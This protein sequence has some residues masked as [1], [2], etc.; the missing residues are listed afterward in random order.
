MISFCKGSKDEP[1]VSPLSLDIPITLP[2]K[3]I[4]KSFSQSG[5][6]SLI[7]KI[8]SIILGKVIGMPKLKGDTA[9]PSFDPLQNEQI[10]PDAPSSKPVLPKNETPNRFWAFVEPYCAPIAQDDIK[11]LEDL[12]KGHSDMT[13]YYKVE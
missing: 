2:K 5:Y 10:R 11:L 4:E 12:I 3:K 6:K 13:E 7:F 9:G 1:A 8:I